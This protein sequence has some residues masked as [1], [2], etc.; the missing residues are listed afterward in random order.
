MM[1]NNIF[2]LFSS[3]LL[4]SKYSRPRNW[5]NQGVTILLSIYIILI[6][7]YI[8]GVFKAPAQVVKPLL[9]CLP[10]LLAGYI[11]TRNINHKV[12]G[13]ILI[14]TLYITSS[15]IIF[16]FDTDGIF[17]YLSFAWV[18][19]TVFIATLF[20]NTKQVVVLTILENVFIIFIF[21]FTAYVTVV[22]FTS[23]Y[24]FNIFFC[25]VNIAIRII[26]D[27]YRNELEQQNQNLEDKVR[28]RTKHIKQNLKEKNILIR[29]LYHRTNN[30]LQLISSLLHIQLD[31]LNVSKEEK[32]TLLKI[33]SQINTMSLVHNRL[34]SSGD[35]RFI[36]LRNYFNDIYEH[37]LDILK[38]DRSSFKIEMQVEDHRIP[39]ELSISLG[40][41]LNEVLMNI[42]LSISSEN[43]LL[44]LQLIAKLQKD[45]ILEIN[46]NDEQNKTDYKLPGIVNNTVGFNLV[47]LLVSK[48]L[49]G[50]FDLND[51]DDAISIKITVPF[52]KI[53][54]DDRQHTHSVF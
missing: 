16:V 46:I 3:A 2:L 42:Y 36:S 30:N 35:L 15:L 20:L 40:L 43:S 29:E 34:Y 53:E 9:I 5:E 51:T 14:G 31:P 50:T 7:T 21:V 23:W 11:I 45:D 12:G 13:L 52:E 22:Q 54:F 6:L 1:K 47:N 26:I 39:L 49:K 8:A 41:I 17:N 27:Y 37:M 19:T 28:K 32:E 44:K 24:F 48:Q 25:L 10:V 33:Y 18:L 38:A 4:K